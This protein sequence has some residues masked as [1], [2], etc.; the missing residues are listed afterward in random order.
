MPNWIFSFFCIF[1]KIFLT[2]IIM[3]IGQFKC[4]YYFVQTLTKTGHLTTRE[5]LIGV[6]L[7]KI[8]K[9]IFVQLVHNHMFP[10]RTH[11]TNKSIF[12]PRNWLCTYI[13]F[14]LRKVVSPANSIHTVEKD[15]PPFV[16][17]SLY[18]VRDRLKVREH[19]CGGVVCDRYPHGFHVVFLA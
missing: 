2:L 16:R 15:D 5:L 10:W 3:S 6:N 8:S 11:G 18:P 14:V 17:L 19:V 9:M 4:C 7:S 13:P 12:T 1:L